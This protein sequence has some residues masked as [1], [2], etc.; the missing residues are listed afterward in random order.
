MG[1][2]GGGGRGE[3]LSSI[4]RRASFPI[5]I[6][7]SFHPYSQSHGSCQESGIHELMNIP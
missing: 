2:P 7:N 3:C 1:S 4:P 5:L 6:P